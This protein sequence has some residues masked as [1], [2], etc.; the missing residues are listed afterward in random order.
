MA[1]ICVPKGRV[2]ILS[3]IVILCD[4]HHHTRKIILACL[5]TQDIGQ[6]LM[7]VLESAALYS[8]VSTTYAP[9]MQFLLVKYRC[10]TK[11]CNQGVKH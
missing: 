2:F 3:L 11:A 8:I 5:A 1:I 4:L 9:T 10:K 6:I 7:A